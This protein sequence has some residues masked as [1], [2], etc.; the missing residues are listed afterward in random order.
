[1]PSPD[2]KPGYVYGKFALSTHGDWNSSAV[3]RGFDYTLDEQTRH[4]TKLGFTGAE[5]QTRAT[6]SAM[7]LHEKRIKLDKS[8]YTEE[9]KREGDSVTEWTIK[10]GRLYHEE[11]DMYMDDMLERTQRFAEESGQHNLYNADEHK[12]MLH[13]EDMIVSGKADSVLYPTWHPNGVR[14][15]PLMVRDGDKVLNAYVDVSRGFR[16]FSTQEATSLLDTVGRR[17]GVSRHVE[18]QDYPFLISREKIAYT[19]VR[20]AANQFVEVKQYQEFRSKMQVPRVYEDRI[21]PRDERP[22]S[23]PV[24]W[25][26]KPVVVD[27]KPNEHEIALPFS[28]GT[29][30]KGHPEPRKLDSQPVQLPFF[31]VFRKFIWNKDVGDQS[32]PNQKVAVVNSDQSEDQGKTEQHKTTDVV[33]TSE[34]PEIQPREEPVTLHE[35]LPVAIEVV[36]LQQ[37]SLFPVSPEKRQTFI[38]MLETAM[39]ETQETGVLPF[40]VLNIAQA[41]SPDVIPVSYLREQETG[42]NIVTEP[43]FNRT[44]ETAAIMTFAQETQIGIGAALFELAFLAGESESPVTIEEKEVREVFSSL[45]E[46]TETIATLMKFISSEHTQEDTLVH[47]K[48]QTGREQSGSIETDMEEKHEKENISSFAHLLL[49]W[50]LLLYLTE[51]KELLVK[52][53]NI[54]QEQNAQEEEDSSSWLLLSI[55]WYL[56]QIREQGIVVVPPQKTKKKKTKLPTSGIVYLYEYPS[57][58]MI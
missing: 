34:I 49:S 58:G 10:D 25:E 36:V 40:L 4:Y 29:I 42:S 26:A 43:L 18:G 38:T 23:L 5:L 37:D 51:A 8:S 24:V 14:Y 35:S 32:R 17:Y 55:I 19:D 16:D 31:E 48:P 21:G 6:A 22:L 1:M 52:L 53:G 2:V 39:Q 7:R 13:M 3:D 28:A 33:K 44:A 20:N 11:Y 47:N 41:P 54:S 45:V 9:I 15:M 27:M 56:S 46:H 12:A 50:E 30:R 57:I